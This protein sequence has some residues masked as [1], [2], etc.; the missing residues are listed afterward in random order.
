MMLNATVLPSW[1]RQRM[2][3]RKEVVRTAMK[4]TFWLYLTYEMGGFR[5]GRVGG[6]SSGLTLEIQRCPGVPPSR[7]NA[8]TSLEV[9]AREVMLAAPISR[10]RMSVSVTLTPVDPVFVKEFWKGDDAAMASLSE[11]TVKS[12]VIIIANPRAASFSAKVYGVSQG[13]ARDTS[14]EK[15]AD[16]HSPG[17]DN[18]CIPHFLR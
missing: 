15:V 14:I 10:A 6:Y 13:G 3:E 1:I 8:Q 9:V 11:P 7:A 4:G 18:R 12:I 17:N 2:K 5:V 16:H